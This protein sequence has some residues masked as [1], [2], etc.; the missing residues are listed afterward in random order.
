MITITCKKIVRLGEAIIQL[1]LPNGEVH[2]ILE[3]DYPEVLKRIEGVEM[4]LEA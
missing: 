3:K 1:T 2:E 4:P